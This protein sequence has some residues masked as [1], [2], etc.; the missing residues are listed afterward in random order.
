MVKSSKA[1][2]DV[3]SLLLNGSNTTPPCKLGIENETLFCLDQPHASKGRCQRLILS[4]RKLLSWGKKSAK[5][6]LTAK[7]ITKSS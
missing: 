2:M 4:F 1:R 7:N 3:D 5:A 6:R